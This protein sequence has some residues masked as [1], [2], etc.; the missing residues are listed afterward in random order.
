MCRASNI[1]STV[2]HLTS[3]IA[4]TK[5]RQSYCIFAFAFCMTARTGPLQLKISEKC[6]YVHMCMY[7]CMSQFSMRICNQFSVVRVLII[8]CSGPKMARLNF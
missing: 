8:V 4:V 7:V 1:Y 6:N 3:L 2:H 5:L